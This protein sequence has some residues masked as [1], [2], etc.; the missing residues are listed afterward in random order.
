MAIPCLSPHAPR[1]LAPDTKLADGSATLIAVG[2]TSRSEFVKHLKSYGAPGGQV[3]L[4]RSLTRLL[5][6]ELPPTRPSGEQIRL[7]LHTN[8][9]SG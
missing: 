2:A 8:P 7:L 6:F 9:L 4:T 1:G 3:R 5:S